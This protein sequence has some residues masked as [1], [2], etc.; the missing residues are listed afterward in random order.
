MYIVKN[1]CVC[2]C[3]YNTICTNVYVSDYVVTVYELPL[4][5]NNTELEIFLQKS[6]EVRSVD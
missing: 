3:M 5:P 4:L 1:M 6:G 2:V